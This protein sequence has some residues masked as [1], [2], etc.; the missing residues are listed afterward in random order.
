MIVLLCLGLFFG[1]LDKPYK[2][3]QTDVKIELTIPKGASTESIAKILEEKEL[4]SSAFKFRVLSKLNG[5]D[6]TL[7]AG[8]YS[9]SPSMEGTAILEALSKG[10]QE[11]GNRVTI[12]EGMTV[13]EIASRLEEKGLVNKEEFLMVAGEYNEGG[14]P[15]LSYLPKGEKRLE[16]FLYPET[17]EFP[18]NATESDIIERMLDQFDKVFDDKAYAK[19]KELGVSPYDAVVIASI[20]EKEAL[21]PE[22]RPL[23][24]SVIY[25]RLEKNMKLQMCAT[26]IYALGY[27]KGYVTTA[28]TK[29]ESPYN[30]YIHEGLTPTPI[31]AP[32]KS[33]LDAALNPAHTDYLYYVLKP[34]DSGTHNF[35]SDFA[36][37]SKDKEAYL[38]YRDEKK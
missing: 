8:D 12:P 25:N 6:G 34:D 7:R 23:I 32:G 17:Y 38:K 15:F 22:D 13:E 36:K 33:S 30:T 5:Y 35:S 37:F 10:G 11:K 29:I 20:I 4:I 2:A 26:V 1:G 24:A 27:N 28:D 18:K 14:H 19:V 31:G 21:K 3:Q 16:G 9:L